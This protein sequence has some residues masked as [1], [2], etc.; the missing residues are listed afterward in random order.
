MIRQFDV[1][2]N[3]IRGSR[4]DKPFLVNVQH[5]FLSASKTRVLAPLVILG[6]IK[7]LTRLYPS[8]LV[9]DRELI[10]TPDDLT[11]LGIQLL[12][13][14]VANLEADRYRIV[15]ALDLVFTGV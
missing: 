12:G 10:L 11:T 3:P 6:H 15:A 4:I 7:Q 5:D 9:L 8:L 13:N 14:P 1:V 2:R